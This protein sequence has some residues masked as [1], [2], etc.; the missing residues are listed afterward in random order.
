MFE[1]LAKNFGGGRLIRL[2]AVCTASLAILLG[3]ETRGQEPSDVPN[4]HKRKLEPKPPIPIHLSKPISNMATVRLNLPPTNSVRDTNLFIRYSSNAIESGL[5]ARYKHWESLAS[6]TNIDS[7]LRKSYLEF[8]IHAWGVLTNY[9]T[10][11]QLWEACSLARL[12]RDPA[13][14]SRAERN[15]AVYLA[16]KLTLIKGKNF[17]TNMSLTEI[18]TE[19]RNEE[20]SMP[21]KFD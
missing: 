5:I 13:K 10:N 11:S 15:L 6:D 8:S 9:Q 19:Y 2:C 4:L 21:Q 16:E 20:P 17:S 1:T 12:S 18:L 7:Q 3:A 14:I